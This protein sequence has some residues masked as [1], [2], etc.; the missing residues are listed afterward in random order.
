MKYILFCSH[1]LMFKALVICVIMGL[2]KAVGSI[3]GGGGGGGGGNSRNVGGS[4]FALF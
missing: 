3:L 1:V 4:R 2:L